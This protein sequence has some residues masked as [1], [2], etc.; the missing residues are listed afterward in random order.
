VFGLLIVLLLA[1]GLVFLHTIDFSVPPEEIPERFAGS[2]YTPHFAS[3]DY[4]GRPVHY[5]EIGDPKKPM[6]VFVHGSPGSWDAF[7]NFMTQQELLER[8]CI[9]SVDRPGFGR[10]G[11]GTPERSLVRQAAALNRVI[12]Q[13][14]DGRPAL[15]VGH[16][17]GGP[18]IVRMAID[19]PDLV[20]GVILVAASVDPQLEQTRW[21]QIPAHWPFIRWML[22][23]LLVSTN[24]E[25][26]ALKGELEAMEPL[27][28]R[29]TVP[30]TV[31][32]GGADDLVPAP[33]ADYAQAHLVNASVEMVRVPDMNHF[34]PW[35]HPGLI[36]DAIEKHLGEG[37]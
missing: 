22:P 6:V 9:I 13:R 21:F 26:L 7:I 33:N 3:L 5:A 8:A 31:I 37:F 18:V 35:N 19:R 17:Y 11:P 34:V 30:V 12:E 2:P 29:I 16:S 4:E 28:P 36:L 15:L 32:Q 14:S 23:D 1:G 24:E 10:S 27:W 25:I 20:A